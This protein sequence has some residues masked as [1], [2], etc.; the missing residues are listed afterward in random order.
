MR[1][2]SQLPIRQFTLTQPRRSPSI[3][4]QLPIRQFT[5]KTR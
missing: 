2:F 1:L 5:S 3:I 4:S